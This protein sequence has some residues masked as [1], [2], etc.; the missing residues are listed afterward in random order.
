VTLALQRRNVQVA[1][2]VLNQPPVEQQGAISRGSKRW[3]GLPTR[4]FG[5]ITVNAPEPRWWRLR[6]VPRSISGARLWSNSYLVAIRGRTCRVPAAGL[7]CTR[8]RQDDSERHGVTGA[9]VPPGVK[10]T[11]HD[12]TQS[13]S[14]RRRGAGDYPRGDLLVSR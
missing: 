1:S 3:G 14:N 11:S 5:N 13:S 9:A 8:D 2:G 4:G 10:Y 12:P 6:D 7:E